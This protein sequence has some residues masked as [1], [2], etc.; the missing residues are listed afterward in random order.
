MAAFEISINGQRFCMV[1]SGNFTCISTQITWIKIPEIKEKAFISVSPRGVTQADKV[2][3]F[4]VQELEIGDE[5]TIRITAS[6][7]TSTV[8]AAVEG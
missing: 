8:L 7:E 5:V 3:H 2:V 4:P 1:E 6:G